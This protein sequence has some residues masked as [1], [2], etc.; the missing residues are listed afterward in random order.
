MG[1]SIKVKSITYGVSVCEPI[2]LWMSDDKTRRLV[3]LPLIHSNTMKNGSVNGI[4]VYQRKKKSD[5]WEKFQNN[6]EQLSKLKS[7]EGYSL[8]LDSNGLTTLLTELL[9]IKEIAD[10]VKTRT[11]DTVFLP[12]NSDIAPLLK[13]LLES[14]ND[15]V[16]VTE[17]QE[18]GRQQCLRINDLILNARIRAALKDW[19]INKN[20]SNEEFWQNYFTSRPWILSLVSPEPIIIM[21]DKM[22]VGGKNA[23]NNGGKIIDYAYINQQTQ[24]LTLIEIKTPVTK[25]LGGSYRD[26]YYPSDEI[27]G[28][29]TQIQNY[30][31][32]ILKNLP[33][34]KEDFMEFDA[35]CVPTYIIAGN[36]D[37]LEGDRIRI[38]SFEFYRKNLR[39]TKIVTF[40]EVF[41]RLSIILN[42]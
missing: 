35:A 38:R 42:R 32:T 41:G 31:Y 22:Y 13:Q 37:Q 3:F 33:S 5:V 25:L 34:L 40:N 12:A 7:G 8:H 14:C 23:S 26:I 2:E 18:L 27:T 39:D 24:N 15:D 10:V 17:L 29:V 20:N 1:E 19:N 6:E 9:N 30:K 11:S 16:V 21:N 36:T 28:A 4:F